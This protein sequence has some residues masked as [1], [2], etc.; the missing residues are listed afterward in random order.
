LELRENRESCQ[1]LAILGIILT[2]KKGKD[3]EYGSGLPDGVYRL[4][5]L[6]LIM[7][8]AIVI[9]NYRRWDRIG[10]DKS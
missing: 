6:C 10:R 1:S 2:V 7:F 3:A 4:C 9:R 8:V 5:G